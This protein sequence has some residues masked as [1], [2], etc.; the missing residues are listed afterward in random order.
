MHEYL[1]HFLDFSARHLWLTLGLALLV[2]AAEALL[3]VGLFVPSTLILVGLGGLVGM[4]K[5][6]F[7][8]VFLATAAG[9]ILGD[10]LSYWVGHHYRERLYGLWP[11]SRYRDLLRLGQDYFSRHGGKSV[12]IGRFIPGIKAVV[13]GIAGMMGMNPWRF[14]LLNVLSALAWAATHLLPGLSAGWV[15]AV[16]AGIS[17]RLAL[18]FALTLILGLL[19]IWLVNRVIRLG[20]Y[21]LPRWH[22]VLVAWVERKPERVHGLSGRIVLAEYANF[23]Q[24]TAMYLLLALALGG[25]LMVLANVLLQTGLG[26]LDPALS[27]GLQGLRTEWSDIPMLAA[28]LSGDTFVITGVVVAVLGVLLYQR[29]HALLT[30]VLAAFLVAGVFI[31]GLKGM[32]QVPRPTPD[33]SSGMDTYS[34]PSGHTGFSTLLAGLLIW[35]ALKGLPG[36]WYRPTVLLLVLLT[37]LISLSRI[38]LGAHWPS[39]VLGS[40]FFSTLLSLVFALV[41]QHEPVSAILSTRI[42]SVAAL[43]FP[44]LTGWHIHSSWDS[45]RQKYQRH[46]APPLVLEQPWQQGGWAA[47]PAY[48]QDLHG[49]REEPFLLQWQGSP[50]SLQTALPDWTPAP[51]WSLAG[52]DGFVRGDTAAPALPAIPKLQAGHAQQLTLIRVHPQGRYLLRLYPQPVAMPEGEVK[53]LWLGTVTDEQL[54]RPLGQFSLP[55]SD[56][57]QVC[58]IDLQQLLPGAQAVGPVL[59]GA[60]EQAGCGGQ[61]VMAGI[62]VH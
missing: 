17:R 39:D 53:T 14:T 49:A 47:L 61:R 44:V 3:V 15:V 24:E 32:M 37:G 2:S 11:F 22:A 23:R 60:P 62:R 25:L 48:R 56:E 27:Q 35:F 18:T 9:A 5:L 13:P 1:Q 40:L 20:L 8:P 30:G 19:L 21:Y 58:N 55:W 51:E 52:L 7:W 28:T 36:R 4:G 54:H 26:G 43:S 41:F 31:F 38:Y 16:L 59:A 45:A 6:P 12:V 33:L 10:A 29:Q 46:P 50:A 34:F 42:L 57:E